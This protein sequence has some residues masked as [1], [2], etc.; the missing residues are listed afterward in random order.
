MQIPFYKPSIGKAE[1]EAVTQVLRSGWITSGPVVEQ[2]EAELASFLG[3]KHVVCT[4]SCTAALEIGLLAVGTQS[5]DQVITSPITFVATAEAIHR[6][7]ARVV[8]SD[9]G[10]GGLHLDPDQLSKNTT[11]FTHAIV[12]MGYGGIPCDMERIRAYAKKNRLWVVEDAAHCFGTAD[13][14]SDVTCFSFHATK[15]LTCGEGGCATTNSDRLAE[16]MRRL[17]QHGLTRSAHQRR[18]DHHYGMTS[19]GIKGN[20]SDINAAIGL[21]QLERWEEINKKRQEV[22]NWYFG[23]GF[24]I[25]GE[26]HGLVLGDHLIAV[27]LNLPPE[28]AAFRDLVFAGMK[29]RGI[30]C[31]IH[32][33]P[34]NTL[35]PETMFDAATHLPNCNAVADRILTLPYF[36][37]MTEEEVQYVVTSLMEVVGETRDKRFLRQ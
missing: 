1:E 27:H 10:A 17:R 7:G 15:Q 8:L 30:E 9:V 12:P 29:K 6:V 24:K 2:F 18:G 26:K 21:V 14:Q 23:G 35:L 36:P 3:V 13:C 19:W 28:P 11:R 25:V 33:P 32:Y 37:D 34:L 4:S 5:S 22:K 20:L 16:K 31:S